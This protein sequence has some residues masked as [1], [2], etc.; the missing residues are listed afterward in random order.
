M[1]VQ[2]Y[3]VG[4]PMGAEQARALISQGLRKAS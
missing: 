4:R 1:L 3:H 2:G